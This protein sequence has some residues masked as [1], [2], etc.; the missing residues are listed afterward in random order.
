MPGTITPSATPVETCTDLELIKASS[1]YCCGVVNRGTY[2]LALCPLH[3]CM[4]LPDLV[5]S[6]IARL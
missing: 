2:N 1:G 3:M 4:H 5:E 6:V